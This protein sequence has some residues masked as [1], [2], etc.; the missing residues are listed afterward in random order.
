MEALDAIT[1]VE[2]FLDSKYGDYAGRLREIAKGDSFKPMRLVINLNDIRR[3][4]PRLAIELLERPSELISSWTEV[5]ASRTRQI[6]NTSRNATLLERMAESANSA[7]LQIQVGFTGNF[8][9]NELSPR[10]L[11]ASH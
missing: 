9:P 7:L 6:L 11:R 4:E 3:Y 10:N 8:G 2:S 5:I 1:I